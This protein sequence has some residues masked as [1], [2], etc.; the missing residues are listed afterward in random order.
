MSSTEDQNNTSLKSDTSV[1]SVHAINTEFNT[2]YATISSTQAASTGVNNSGKSFYYAQGQNTDI[3]PS[4]AYILSTRV[5]FTEGPKIDTP[6]SSTR[7]ANVENLEYDSDNKVLWYVSAG[8]F[9][10]ILFVAL[11]KKWMNC[12]IIKGCFLSYQLG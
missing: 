4:E 5:L 1:L 8:C 7:E 6:N 10:F 3:V 2:S 9:F 11:F 12:L